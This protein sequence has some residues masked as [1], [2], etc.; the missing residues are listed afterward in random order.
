MIIFYTMM[1]PFML[2]SLAEI[3]LGIPE[4]ASN[5][6]YTS[7]TLAILILMICII[8]GILNSLVLVFRHSRY[9]DHPTIQLRFNC[10]FTAFKVNSLFSQLF[11]P[12]VMISK[13]LNLYILLYLQE[14]Q[15]IFCI[16]VSVAVRINFLILNI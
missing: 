14:F 11:F 5:Y 15:S 16:V 6:A 8:G 4:N 9:S 3:Q 10:L 12:I 13:V 2:A 7:F 1:I